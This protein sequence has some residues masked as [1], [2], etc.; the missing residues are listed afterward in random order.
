[1]I[2]ASATPAIE[3]RHQVEIGR[4]EEIK[5]P[6][7]YG[8]AEL[9]EI[10]GID[11]TQDPPERGHWIAPQLVA[12]MRET[13]EKGE[14]SLLFLNRRGYAPLTLCR[15]CGHRFQ[16]PNCTAWMVEHRLTR[17]LALPSFAGM[18]CRTPDCLPGM[19]AAR[20]AGRLRAGAWNASPMKCA[21]SFR[22]RAPPSSPPTRSG[23][24]RRAAAFVTGMAEKAIDI[25]VGTQLVTK[26]YHFPELT[27][28]GVI[29]AD[30]GL[31][32]GDLRAAERTYQQIVQVSGARRARREAGA[33]VH[34]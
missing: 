32:G 15:H 14:Q 16:C 25:V 31:N 18:K 10:I 20:R 28:V 30:L 2:L 13:L 23:R 7:R 1:M 17:R 26:G 29:D 34:P 4:Y 22:R 33:G 5:L 21:L 9:P 6:A 8:G 27:L 12:A 24:R 11:L 3:T 19:Q